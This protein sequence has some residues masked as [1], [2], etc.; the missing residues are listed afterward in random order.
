MDC[1]NFHLSAHLIILKLAR[2]DRDA[3]KRTLVEQHWMKREKDISEVQQ[4]LDC[5]WSVFN[6]D[7]QLAI[8]QLSNSEIQT[9]QA[10]KSTVSSFLEY[11][12][13]ANLIQFQ[14]PVT[15]GI[16]QKEEN[17]VRY[18][19]ASRFI[20]TFFFYLSLSLS[21]SSPTSLFSSPVFSAKQIFIKVAIPDRNS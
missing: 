20:P 13:E 2:I 5:S 7:S 9:S 4:R 14:S 6:T 19:L 17:R 11:G 10:Q 18:P 1:L 8:V 21:S 15:I 12:L 16:F 3:L